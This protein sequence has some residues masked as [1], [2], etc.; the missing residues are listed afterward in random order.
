MCSFWIL[1]FT[2]GPIY[3]CVHLHYFHE[4]MSANKCAVHGYYYAGFVDKLLCFPMSL[5]VTG[6]VVAVSLISLM[7]LDPACV[8]A[9]ACAFIY[10]LHFTHLHLFIS[11][12]D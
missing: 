9:H 4:H 2:L 7:G 3:T 11:D 12:S 1:S 6:E 5:N 10:T 8:R